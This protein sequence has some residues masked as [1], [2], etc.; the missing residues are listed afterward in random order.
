MKF[1]GG[2]ERRYGF[3]QFFSELFRYGGRENRERRNKRQRGVKDNREHHRHARVIKRVRKQDCSGQRNIFN[4]T[5]ASEAC[6]PVVHVPRAKA[7]KSHA[8][9]KGPGPCRVLVYSI[10]ALPRNRKTAKITV[11]CKCNGINIGEGPQSTSTHA[12]F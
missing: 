9:L 3:L 6:H 10:A 4:D 11:G 2:D 5:S 1:K 7:L 8:N 12:R